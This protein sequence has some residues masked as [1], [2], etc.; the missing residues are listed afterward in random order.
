MKAVILTADDFGLSAEVNAGIIRAHRDGWLTAASL[1]VG[2]PARDGAVAAARECP[3]LDVGLHVVVCRGSSVLGADRVPGLVN[4]A[5]R[6]T[7]APVL[8]GLRYFFSRRLRAA[9]GDECRAQVELHLKLVGPLYHIDGHLNFQAHPALA[10]ILIA[11]AAEYR[12]PYLRVPHEPVFTTLK[13]SPDYPARKLL[14]AAIF[15][16]LGRRMRR[17]MA[18]HGIRS[19]D[20]LFG[21]HQTGNWTES[22]VLGLIPGL[23][24]GVTE[25]YFHPA[26][27]VGATPPPPDQQREVEI[28]T[29]SALRQTLSIHG[30]RLTSFAEL[31][32]A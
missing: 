30:V 7:D 6:F 28:L 16:V 12:V 4:A 26:S 20:R 29:G 13:L 11:L 5:G 27:D 21:L 31:A 2:A 25:M 23:G 17:L 8:G 15:R 22:H 19:A 10:D 3:G 18:A 32:R 9:L 14:E 1:M 24:E